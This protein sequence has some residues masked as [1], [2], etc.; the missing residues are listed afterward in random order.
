VVGEGQEIEEQLMARYG[1]FKYG[2]QK[3]GAVETDNLLW[4]LEV[5][6]DHDGAFSERGESGRIKSFSIERGKDGWFS[7]DA[8]GRARFNRAQIGK[9][10]IVLDNYDRRFSPWYT[11]SPLYP[12]V[13]S[14]REIRFRVKNG[15]AGDIY[16][17][18]RGRL[19]DIVCSGGRGE[20]TARLEAEDGWRLLMDNDSTIQLMKDVTVDA[21]MDGVLDDVDWPDGWGRSVDTGSDMIPY[22]WVNSQSGFDAVHDMAESDMGLATIGGD[23]Q[24]VFRSRHAL[25]TEEEALTLDQSEVL[26]SPEIGNPVKMIKNRVSV[27]AF[28][29]EPEGE[30]DVWQLYDVPALAPG[31]TLEM[32]GT[33]H[34]S[35][36]NETVA[37]DVIAPVATTDYL[38]NSQDDGGGNDLTGNLS[39]TATAFSGSAKFELH[40]T[41]AVGG[42]VTLLKIRGKALRLLDTIASI[43]ENSTSQSTYG[44]HQMNLELPFQQQVAVAVDMSNWLLSWMKDPLPTVV[45]EILNRP[46]LQ[47]AY[48]LGAYLRFTSDY[49]GI[50]HRFRIAKIKHESMESMQ[51]IKTTW[52]LEPVDQVSAYWQLGVAG[53]SEIGETTRLAF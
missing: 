35:L 37:D 34:D 17:L 13:Q 49:F 43:V 38:L 4:A 3:Y 30:A 18:F 27:K 39:V 15:T 6:W 16:N 52:T 10:S 23:G 44:V 22:G 8:D 12:N 31:Q 5:D 20:E 40:N 11:S 46:T 25:L 19:D 9:A 28:P 29:R 53:F 26:D 2:E 50:D 42:Y 32:W 21:M 24:F 7:V 47:F 51:S 41:G 1:T 48:D 45:V 33:F 14:N 36:G